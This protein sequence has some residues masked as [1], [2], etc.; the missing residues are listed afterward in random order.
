MAILPNREPNLTPKER[1]ELNWEKEAT[2]LQIQYAEKVK[3][4]DL[5]LRRLEVKWTSLFRLPQMLLLL[6]V[7]LVLS[8]AV[9]IAA[10]SGKELPK[11]YWEFLKHV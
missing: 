11:E 9:P 8:L 3:E 6:P 1:E 10:V 5:E 7:R 2:H 4:M